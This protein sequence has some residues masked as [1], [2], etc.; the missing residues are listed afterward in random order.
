MQGDGSKREKILKRISCHC[1]FGPSDSSL[2]LPSDDASQV[3]KKGERRKRKKFGEG[4]K[5][6]CQA[7]FTVVVYKA[8]PDE[9]EIRY[10][11]DFNEA[12]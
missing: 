2:N 9:I 8:K 12:V 7:A 1:S 11:S 4:T 3:L 6:G 10:R 5:K